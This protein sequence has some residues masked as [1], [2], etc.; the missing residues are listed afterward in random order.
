MQHT[1]WVALIYGG[2]VILGGV[3]GFLKAHSKVSLVSGLIFGG[4]LVWCGWLLRAGDNREALSMATLLAVTLLALFAVRFLN[5]RK[6][7]PAGLLAILS[8]AAAGWFAYALF[9]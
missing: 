4:V 3:L 5:H 1:A 9:G 8:A 6:F 7:M 2:L